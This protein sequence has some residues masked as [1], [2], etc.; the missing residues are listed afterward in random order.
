[1]RWSLNDRLRRSSE[2]RRFGSLV[3]ERLDA[4]ELFLHPRWSFAAGSLGIGGA[5]R[6]E[7]FRLEYR[8][9][10]LN[11]RAAT[12]GVTGG[13]DPFRINARTELWIRQQR[14]E[15]G[16]HIARP[17]PEMKPTLWRA[18][19]LR[20]RVAVMCDGSDDV[21]TLGEIMTE[22]EQRTCLAR[23]AMR[24]QEQWVLLRCVR[25]RC[26]WDH[27]L[28]DEGCIGSVALAGG[29][30]LGP[31]LRRIPDDGRHRA[32]PGVLPVTTF[33]V[34][35]CACF[36][37]NGE[38]RARVRIGTLVAVGS[39]DDQ[40]EYEGR[41]QYCQ[42]TFHQLISNGQSPPPPNLSPPSPQP[43]S[44][45]GRGEG[46]LGLISCPRANPSRASH[47][48]LSPLAARLSA[49]R[50]TDRGEGHRA[51][52]NASS[53]PCQTSFPQGRRGDA[54]VR[55]ATARTP[56]RR[57][58]GVTWMRAGRQGLE[59]LWPIA[60]QPVGGVLEAVGLQVDQ[61]PAWTPPWAPAAAAGRNDP[62]SSRCPR[63]CRHGWR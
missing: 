2:A 46:E 23:S 11:H 37:A 13:T 43:L 4:L 56:G 31:G 58:D 20:R 1:M 61:V 36:L 60:E 8:A 5:E 30:V 10:Q 24:Q 19:R 54:M 35:E 33:R 52:S 34:R 42:Q 26:L 47:Q 59:C 16:A 15:R 29:S 18:I 63:R 27:A 9:S 55:P 28:H 44:R 49:A 17:L 48:S 45:K 50:C 25:D 41:C 51:S 7:L 40:K 62:G 14:I 38:T 39:T 12:G 21:S 53:S 32:W 6:V 22:P 3:G 57:R